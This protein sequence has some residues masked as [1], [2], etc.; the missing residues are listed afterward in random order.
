MLAKAATALAWIF[1]AAF[2]GNV[3]VVTV[4]PE[5]AETAVGAEI[6]ALHVLSLNNVT[7][8]ASVRFIV[9]VGVLDMPGVD[10]EID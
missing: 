10:G 3:D 4:C 5:P 1:V 8:E 7:V 6:A 9:T 2:A